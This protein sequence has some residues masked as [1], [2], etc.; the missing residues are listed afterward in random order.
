M[1]SY[2][3]FQNSDPPAL[4]EIWRSQPAEH[5]RLQSMTAALLEQFVFAKPYFDRQGLIVAVD[6]EQVVGFA[7]A[8]FGPSDD[9][10]SLSKQ[11]GL[12]CLVMVRP[13]YRRRGIGAEL[14]ARSEAYLK[15]QGADVIYGGGVAPLN[16][17][18]LG[19]YGG[20]E[21]PG[22]LDSDAGEQRLF[23][24]HGYR[25]ID[26][27]HVL[28]RDLTGFR[29]PVDRQQMQIRRRST[30]QAIFDPPPRTWWQAC[31]WSGLERTRFELTLRDVGRVVASAAVWSLEPLS[32]SWGVQ[33]AGIIELEVEAEFRRQ[34]IATFLVGEALRQLH[35]QGVALVQVQA[36]QRNA[37]ALALYEKLGFRSVNQGAVY[38]KDAGDQKT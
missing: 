30:V 32:G 6:G 19:L 28:E 7:H 3:V 22:V 12:T 37:P 24:A 4:A 11:F 14:L 15:Q 21:L 31:A 36:M 33:A 34:G 1:I 23:C 10:Q 20:S 35:A 16:G 9:E 38:R 27:I 17:F 25:E 2:R 5:G 26:R 18:Y 8:A 29:P 13:E